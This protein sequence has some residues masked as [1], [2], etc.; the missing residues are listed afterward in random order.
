M[1]RRRFGLADQMKFA[2]FSSDFNP[3]YIDPVASRRLIY[4]QPVVPGAT[5]CRVRWPLCERLPKAYDGS[6][7]NLLVH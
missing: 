3:I 6:K 2:S 1:S 4:G 7:P 5:P